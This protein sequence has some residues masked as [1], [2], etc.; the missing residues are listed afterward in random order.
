MK[1][2]GWVFLLLTG[3]IATPAWAFTPFVIKDI[4]VEGLKRIAAGTVFNYLPVQVGDTM[5]D[6]LAARCIQ[7]LFKTGFFKDVRMERSGD[8]LLVSV[9]ERPAIA[10]ITIS[11][12]KEIKTKK[13][14][15]A[16]KQIGLAQGQV[17]DRSMLDKVEQE[18]RQQYFNLGKYGVKIKTTVTPLPRNRVAIAIDISE[19]VVAKIR[20]ITIVGNKSFSEKRLL[21]HFKLGPPTLFSFFTGNDQYSREKLAGDLETLR[22]Y[23][24]DRGYINFNINSTEV[25]ITPDKKHIYITIDVTE[26][27]KYTVKDVKLAGKLILPKTE[28]QKLIIVKPGTTFSRKQVTQSIE[29]IS[30][31]LGDKGYAF[32][33]VNA[34]PG[35]DKKDKVVSLTFFV[36]P[37]QRVYVRRINFYGNTKTRDEVLRREMRQMEGGLLSTKKVKRSRTRLNRLG[38]LKDITVQTPRV[39]G[40]PDQVDVNYSVKEQPSGNFI[41]G[42]GYAQ[43]EGVLLNASINE[44]N[45]FGTGKR[46]SLVFN[47]SSFYRTYSF[48]YL[49]PYYTPDGISR[50]FNLY[51]QKTFAAAIN[52]AN[53]TTDVVGGNVNYGIPVSEYDTI[54]LGYGYERT[55]IFT[56][57]LSSTQITD[58]I[59]QNGSRFNTVK[60]TAGWSHDT[61]NRAIFPNRGLLQSVSSEIAVPAGKESLEYYKLRYEGQWYHPLTKNLTL[62]LSTHLGYGNGYGKT[63]GLPFFTNF[64][65]GGSAGVRGFKDYTLGPVDSNGFPLGGNLKT[66]GSAEVIF[67]TPFFKT[68]AVRLSTFVDVGNVFGPGQRFQANQ[69][70]YSTGVSL[71]WMSPLGPLTFSLAKPLN[72]KTGDQ[73]QPFQFSIGFTY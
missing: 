1:K 28:L 47:N 29:K 72:V 60:L 35:V 61:R 12:N 24:L 27:H 50:G 66:V 7:A 68:N 48:S 26:G 40:T 57:P 32:A 4:R 31:Q 25:S 52:I 6:A 58:F 62:L 9:V 2:I 49:N 37:G 65:A 11:G 42:I 22:S 13:L 33:N 19:G 41:A 36:E 10:S 16:L 46:A 53:F 21:G 38:Y 34:V 14:L 8:V 43:T 39:P 70:R 54:S 63:H 5:D 67:P 64:Y 56:T 15:D 59:A 17:F 23:Y 44:N 71:I 20:Q 51:D 69:L 30:E 18:L 55:S 45:L 3:L 73:T